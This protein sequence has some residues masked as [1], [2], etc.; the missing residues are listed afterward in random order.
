MAHYTRIQA[1]SSPIALIPPTEASTRALTSVFHCRQ[2]RRGASYHKCLSAPAQSFALYFCQVLLYD[3][4]THSA[5][6]R[7]VTCGAI[8][9]L[10]SLEPSPW[11]RSAESSD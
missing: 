6:T 5:D 8:Y 1:I 9:C 11:G 3:R 2:I 4:P 10:G 7:A